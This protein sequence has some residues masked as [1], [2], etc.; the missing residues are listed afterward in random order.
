M[1]PLLIGISLAWTADIYLVDPANETWTNIPEF[2]FFFSGSEALANCE[3][4]INETPYGTELGVWNDTYA[5]I[6]PN[7]TVD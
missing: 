5:T 4:F 2:T 3:L 7:D 6:V 1:I